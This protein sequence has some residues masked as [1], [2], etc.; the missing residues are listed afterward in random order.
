[1]A[2]TTILAAG[3]TAATSSD[4]TVASGASIKIGID[5][6]GA[7]GPADTLMIFEVGPLGERPLL[8]LN[9]SNP[10][11][12]C[13]GGGTFRVKRPITTASIAVFTE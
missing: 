5:C 9:S 8:Q 6:A 13:D 4:V 1:M 11:T 3:T 2:Q 10:S 12:I 7:I